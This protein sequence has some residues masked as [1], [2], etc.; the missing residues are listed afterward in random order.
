MPEVEGQMIPSTPRPVAPSTPRAPTTT[1]AGANACSVN[2]CVL[3]GGHPGPHKDGQD[4]TFSWTAQS[5]RVDL[6]GDLSSD[7]DGSS[8]SSV[9]STSSEELKP[10]LKAMETGGERKRKDPP[11]PGGMYVLEVEVDAEEASYLRAHPRKA[12]IWLSRR[13]EEKSKEH[14]WQHLSLDEKK[15]FDLAQAR[16]LTNVLQSKALRSLTKDE[17]FSLDPRKCMKMRWVLTTKSSGESKA[18]LVILGYQQHNLT[19]VQAAAPT[20]SRMSRCMLLATCANLK[21]KLRSG[22]VTSAFLQTSKSIE[23]EDL[24]VWATPEL[25]VLFGASPQQPWLPLKVSKAF[26]GL[27]HAPRAW[28]EDVSATLA[29]TSWIKMVSDGCLFILKEG[30]EVVGIAGI[31]VDDFLIGGREDSVVFQNAMKEL[32][33]AYRWG[34]WQHDEFTF[35]GCHI[36]QDASYNIYVDQNEYSEKWMDEIDLSPERCRQPKSPATPNEIS[37]LRGVIG[38][39]AWRSSQTSPHFQADVGLLLSEVPYATVDTL[40]RANKLVREVRRSPHSLKFHSWGVPWTDLSV[41]VWADASNSN[42]PDKSSTM[43]IV[44]GLAP[45]GILNGERHPVS[46]LQWKSSKTPRQ[47]LGSN[48]AEVQ[49]ITEGE[50]LC[51]RLR[52]LLCEIHG[53]QITRSNLATVVREKSTGALVMD[54]KGIYDSMTRN[55]SALHGLKSGR[56]GYELTISVSQAL[57]VQTVLRW[58]NG[59][60]QLADCLTK[61]GHSKKL[62][63][64]FLADG[65]EWQLV[66][67]PDFVAG[68]KLKRRALEQK[69]KEMETQFIN[70]VERA[71]ELYRWPF[72]ARA[73]PTELRIMGDELIQSWQHVYPIRSAWVGSSASTAEGKRQTACLS[74]HRP[75]VTCR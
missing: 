7:D 56:A 2:E 47:C 48:G 12:A 45:S 72:I 57:E 36:H 8:T 5:G 25:A 22:D 66:H 26:Y 11:D 64:K 29:R 52:A 65:Q 40:M 69:L 24:V 38:T 61:G 62:F 1:G 55:V 74:H 3:P 17:R 34:K 41:I 37:Q 10:D 51:F 16:E 23:S 73:D 44:A 53:E 18:R 54:S 60:S 63:M 19:E 67:D 39:L 27:V 32:E 50:D 28:Y 70:A 68:K 75:L 71:A 13:M 49:S 6:E 35:A 59:E 31:H 58:V 30:D 21:F 42:R 4:K 46:L 15:S 33:Q 9:S 20:M 43:G 14:H